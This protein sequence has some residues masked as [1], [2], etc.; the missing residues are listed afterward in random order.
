LKQSPQQRETPQRGYA[1]PLA[2]RSLSST[3][4]TRFE[5]AKKDFDL[6]AALR[7]GTP[8][9]AALN[10]DLAGVVN[11]SGGESMVPPLSKIF[12]CTCTTTSPMDAA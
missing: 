4:A 10:R 8:Q 9:N 11:G 2:V 3:T 5:N 12:T 6:P 7:S 1:K